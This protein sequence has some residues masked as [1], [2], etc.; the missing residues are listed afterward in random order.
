MKRLYYIPRNAQGLGHLAAGATRQTF[1]FRP[2][3]HN[4]IYL[5]VVLAGKPTCR[6]EL[7]SDYCWQ[8]NPPGAQSA[9]PHAPAAPL[10]AS[11][12]AARFACDDNMGVTML[13]SGSEARTSKGDDTFTFTVGKLDA[14]MAILIGERASLIEF[15]SLLLPQ[16]VT[17]G[18]VVNI[19]VLRNEDEEQKQKADFDELQEEI[20]ETFG[21]DG[22]VGEF[23]GSVLAC[24]GGRTLMG[25][26]LG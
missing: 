12:F 20:M 17:S 25:A 4:Q 22:P 26:F 9:A 21:K 3:E 23:P 7:F 6:T 14:G 13:P 2:F 10:Y 18:S 15:P 1:H 5:T 19:R 11:L 16:G 8:S 24:L